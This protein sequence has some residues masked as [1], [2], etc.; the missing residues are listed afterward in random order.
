MD[1][2]FNTPE[3]IALLFDLVREINRLRDADRPQANALAGTLLYLGSI[4]GL[5]QTDPESYLRRSG[6]AAGVAEGDVK[7]GLSEQEIEHLIQAR[8]DARGRKDWSTA[9]QVRQR[10]TEAGIILEDG[11]QGTTWRRQMDR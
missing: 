4:L 10:L 11:P 2:D 9:D 7:T 8:N 5:L 1:D 3:A 6:P